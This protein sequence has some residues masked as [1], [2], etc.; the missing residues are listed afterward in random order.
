MPDGDD[1]VLD[2][3]VGS[4]GPEYVKMNASAIAGIDK[5]NVEVHIT[6]AGGSFG[7]H[8]SAE[9]DPTAEAVQ[10]ARALNWKHQSKSSR[11]ARRSSRSAGTGRRLYT[12]C[13][14]APTPTVD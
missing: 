9:R 6:F 2:V 3:W 1:G 12:G 7:L 8:L 13:V 10:I 11:C 14:P 5:E 4:E